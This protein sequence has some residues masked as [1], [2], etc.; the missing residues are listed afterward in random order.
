MSLHNSRRAD[1][2]T[3]DIID[4]AI[5]SP[6]R[7]APT[8]RRPKVVVRRAPTAANEHEIQKAKKVVK[9]SFKRE[10]AWW[11]LDLNDRIINGIEHLTVNFPDVLLPVTILF[12]MCVPGNSFLTLGNEDVVRFW[13][14]VSRCKQKMLLKYGRSFEMIGGSKHTA[15][16]IRGYTSKEQMSVHEGPKTER[17]IINAYMAAQTLSGAIGRPEQLKVSANF[18]AEQKEAA[19]DFTRLVTTIG[20]SIK[21]YLPAASVTQPTATKPSTK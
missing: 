6:G 19:R 3:D 20:Q 21:G 8:P 18:T 16:Y 17:R 11:N 5:G 13:K 12:W 4:N 15:G 9:K 10:N 7:A 1:N 14:R 2:D